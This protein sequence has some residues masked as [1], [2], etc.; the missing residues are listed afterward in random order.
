[1]VDAR[2]Y[3]LCRDSKTRPRLQRGPAPGLP[4]GS[5]HSRAGRA[6]QPA[7]GGP[8]DPAPHRPPSPQQPAPGRPRRRATARGHRRTRAPAASCSP[9]PRSKPTT[10]YPTGASCGS[11]RAWPSS[12]PI[13]CGCSATTNSPSTPTRRPS[14]SPGSTPPQSMSTSPAPRSTGLSSPPATTPW[15]TCSRSQPTKSSPATNPRSH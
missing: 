9:C 11:P 6:A 8:Q 2:T 14:C 1:M 3:P 10:T 13:H 15:S 4:P 5:V 12:A 7:G